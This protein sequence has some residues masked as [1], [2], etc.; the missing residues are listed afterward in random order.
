MEAYPASKA[1]AYQATKKFVADNNT[2]F[3]LINIMPVY[4]IGRDETVSDASSIAK[5]TNG[6]VMGPLL[7][8]PL[9]GTPN[10]LTVHVDDVAKM[11]VLSLD[12]KVEGNQDYLAAGPN[13]GS[14]AWADSFAVV[15]K[16]Y[17]KEYADGVFKF[18]SVPE[19]ATDAGRV[20]NSKAV[21]AFGIQFKS[22]EEQVVSVVDHFLE[23]TGRR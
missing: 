3:D 12:P 2:S 15:K 9:P 16:R 21:K 13:F 14:I 4:V 11:H 8:Y 19:P 1:L 18:E 20:D 17:P 10:G 6:L 22:F 5:G 7:G 23:L